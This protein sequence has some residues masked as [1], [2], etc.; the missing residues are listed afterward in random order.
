MVVLILVT[1]RRWQAAICAAVRPM[2]MIKLFG[3]GQG[4]GR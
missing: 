2:T 1:A 4:R 3:G